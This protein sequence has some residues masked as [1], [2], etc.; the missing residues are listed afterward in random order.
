MTY[1]TMKLMTAALLSLLPF[2]ASAADHQSGALVLANCSF[3]MGPYYPGQLIERGVQ[4]RVLLKV[5]R[6]KSG[7]LRVL[8][9][10]ASSPRN[11]FD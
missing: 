9:V 8:S 3:R 7:S 6:R 11:A 4:G 1:R 5:E 2:A 10:E